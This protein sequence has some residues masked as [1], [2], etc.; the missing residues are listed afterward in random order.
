M[1]QFKSIKNTNPVL[2]EATNLVFDP[3]YLN[4]IIDLLNY[5]V[6]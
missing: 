2:T 5:L 1:H 4:T 6:L 3:K